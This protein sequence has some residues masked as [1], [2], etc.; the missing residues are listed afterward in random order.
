MI[1]NPNQKEKIAMYEG[2]LHDMNMYCVCCAHEKIQ[3][4]VTNADSWSYMHRCG[5]GS[6]TERE[7]QRNINNAFW[8][9][10]KVE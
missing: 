8:N 2:F 10:R 4:L 6:L 7:Q 1:K 9:L 5:D 3:R